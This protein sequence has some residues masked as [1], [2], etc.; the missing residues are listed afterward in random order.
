MNVLKVIIFVYLDSIDLVLSQK[1]KKQTIF[2][3]PDGTLCYVI[4]NISELR[5]TGSL[6]PAALTVKFL[7]KRF[8]SEYDPNLGEFPSF[9]CCHQGCSQILRGSKV[10]V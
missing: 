8:I 5:L 9:Y 3:H 4:E 6:S 10:K 2:H 1:H 7:T